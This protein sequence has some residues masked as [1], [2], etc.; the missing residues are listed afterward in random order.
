MCKFDKMPSIGSG[1]QKEE[2]D[3]IWTEIVWDHNN[4]CDMRWL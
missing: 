2:W 1:C 3:L 4:M